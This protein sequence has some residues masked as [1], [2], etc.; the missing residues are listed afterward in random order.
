MVYDVRLNLLISL[1]QK[2]PSIPT[3]GFF[4][5]P[6]LGSRTRAAWKHV[7]IHTHADKGEEEASLLRRQLN[8]QKV[9]M[10]MQKV[11]HRR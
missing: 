7:H 8:H 2:L 5:G 3:G 11:T 6:W 9:P 1:L 4:P 10:E